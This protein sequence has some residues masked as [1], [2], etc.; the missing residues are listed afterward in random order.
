MKI[1]S[2]THDVSPVAATREADAPAKSSAAS[3]A[4]ASKDAVALSAH[5]AGLAT[6][7]LK[8]D[9]SGASPARMK[10]LADALK[11]GTYSVDHD[12]LANRMIDMD[13][14]S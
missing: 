4:P 6:V 7:S 2:N 10:E 9:A 14:H 5:A 1:G 8:G 12:A 3:R 11:S 13:G